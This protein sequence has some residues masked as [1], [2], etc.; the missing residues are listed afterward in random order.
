MKAVITGATGCVGRHLTLELINQG[1]KVTA[2]GRNPEVGKLLEENGATFIPCSLNDLPT[3]T[4]AN[5]NA[6]IVFH[7]AALSSAWGSVKAFYEN[8]VLGTKNVI[9]AAQ[10]SSVKRLV[11]LS[12]PSIYFDYND[13]YHISELDSLPAKSVNNYAASKLESERLVN[14]AASSGLETV[15]LRPRGIIGPYDSALTPRLVRV[16]KKGYLPVFRNG[17]AYV[18]VTC[19]DNLVDA[20]VNAATTSNDV[21]GKIY[22]ISNGAPVTIRTMLSEVIKYLGLDARIINLPYAPAMTITKAMEYIAR[23]VTPSWE[24]PVTAYSLSLLAFGQTLDITAAKKDLHYNPQVSL[25]EGL[26]KL[27]DWWRGGL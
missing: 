20:M 6:D 9:E 5:S 11:F 26:E 19:V 15:S 25:N 27:A 7:C 18:D 23:N 1:W 13:R 24:P 12:S 16:A 8:N 21:S 14:A 2:L 22:N 17:E 10:H 3:L 4:S